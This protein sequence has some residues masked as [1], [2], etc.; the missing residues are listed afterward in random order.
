MDIDDLEKDLGLSSDDDNDNSNDELED[1][2]NLLNSSEDDIIRIKNDTEIFE[3]LSQEEL[4]LLMK[5]DEELDISDIDTEVMNDISI[6]GESEETPSQEDL[7]QAILNVNDEEIEENNE[8]GVQQSEQ[9][10]EQENKIS[11]EDFMKLIQQQENG[12]NDFLEFVEA[13]KKDKKSKKNKNKKLSESSYNKLIVFGIVFLSVLIVG[14][15][16]FFIIAIQTINNKN[17][18]AAI[19]QDNNIAAKYNPEDKNTV[20]VDM[21]QNIDDETLI[22][23]KVHINQSNTTFY[24]KN[25]IEPMK[26]NIILTD[27]NE[28]LYPMDLN[29]TQDGKTG[30]SILRFDSIVGESKDLKLIFKSIVTGKEA[31]FNL[32]FDANLSEE[33]V[34]YI[35]SKIKNNFGDFNINI[36]YAEFGDTSSR[37]DYIIEPFGEVK[38]Q[39]QQGILN[40]K[41]SVKLKENNKYIEELSNNPVSTSID[42]KIIGRMDF[43]NIKDKNNN[44]VLE[45]NNIYKKYPLN[46]KVTL[47][48]VKNGNLV[49]E[50]DNYRLYIEGMPRFDNKYVL[51]LHSED[52]TINTENKPPNA[53]RVDTK[54]DVEIVATGKDGVDVIISPTE[55]KSEQYGTDI[56]FDLDESQMNLLNGISPNNININ[57][58]SVLLKEEQVNIPINLN[59]GMERTI[60]SHDIMEG[61]IAKSFDSRVKSVN[62]AKGFSPEVLANESLKKEYMSLLGKNTKSSINIIS[63][64]LDNEYL[65][66]IVQEAI[67]VKE[68]DDIKVLYKIHKIKANN[69]NNQWTIYSDEIIK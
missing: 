16:M 8:G 63:K 6:Y 22:L 62:N 15:A 38:Y 66:A 58:K 56:I 36:N 64:N 12:E 26:Y 54:L 50:F 51:V 47:N 57:I 24:F 41:D 59:R 67:Q 31:L 11:Q 21:A 65:E 45:F 27:A 68:N 44:T 37:I 19:E 55:I 20:Y 35:N 32:N 3:G 17:I 34:S 52:K 40:E 53:N 10:D 1:I 25:K 43:K 23:E 4:D 5:Q 49:Y 30:N 29:F 42:N 33:K 61:Q 9:S 2:I 18:Q 69:V 28:N 13:P 14:T 7:D 48:E 60:I 39:I 46:K